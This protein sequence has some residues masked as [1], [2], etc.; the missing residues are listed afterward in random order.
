MKRHEI[1]VGGFGGQGIILSGYII[2]QAASLH[3]GNNS[4]LTQS[5]GPEARGGACSAELVVAEDEIHNPFFRNPDILVVMSQ[6]SY[7]LFFPKLRK[8]G[9]I[10]IDEDLVRPHDG[11]G[12]A[13]MFAIPA[14]KMAEELGRRIIANIVMLGFFAAM[15]DV[16]TKDAMERAISDSVPKG[17]EELNL[18][19]F[20]AG[21]D[22]GKGMNK[23][24]K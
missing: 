15:T 8:G 14:T 10:L 2:G 21:F 20:R 3:D 23:D 19:A 4:A 6:E 7:N 9:L 22:Y 18:K 11:N 24:R 16:V 5:Y 17:T 13:R 1:K 12:K